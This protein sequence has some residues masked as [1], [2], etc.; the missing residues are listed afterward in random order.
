MEEII[1][2]LKQSIKP[3]RVLSLPSKIFMCGGLVDKD[4]YEEPYLS[5]RH[6]IFAHMKINEQDLFK[7]IVLADYVNFWLQ[8]SNYEDLLELE[9]DLAGLVSCIPL[10]LESPGSY[11]ELG[12][13]VLIKHISEKLLLFTNGAYRDDR[14]FI[15]LGPIKRLENDHGENRVHAHIWPTRNQNQSFNTSDALDH[16]ASDICKSIKIFSRDRDNSRAF[17]P[18]IAAH[19]ILLICDIINLLLI[20]R[21]NE[22]EEVINGLTIE[23]DGE[24]F[25]LDRK[26]CKKYILIARKLELIEKIHDGTGDDAYYV[27]LDPAQNGFIKYNYNTEAPYTSRSAWKIMIKNHIEKTPD[28]SRR[29]GVRNGWLANLGEPQS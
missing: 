16:L 12:S 25:I 27:S 13:F 28:L 2:K 5:M 4:R 26:T 20:S 19:K 10:F 18:K 29:K 6:F 11:A 9:E 17:N 21:L 8:D 7:E 1:Q 15:A 23:V 24:P 3:E 14:S 22:I